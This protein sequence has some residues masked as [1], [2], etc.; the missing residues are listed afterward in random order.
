MKT[1]AIAAA[2]TLTLFSCKPSTLETESTGTEVVADSTAT[3]STVTL[4]VDT[5]AVAE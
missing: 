3:D 4:E 5:P 2:I 1:I